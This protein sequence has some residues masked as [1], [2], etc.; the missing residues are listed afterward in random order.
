MCTN[1]ILVQSRLTN[2][3]RK[4]LDVA[5]TALHL[6]DTIDTDIPHNQVLPSDTSHRF[7]EVGVGEGSLIPVVVWLGQM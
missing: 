4:G 2:I 6:T 5:L 1:F 3:V 7:S